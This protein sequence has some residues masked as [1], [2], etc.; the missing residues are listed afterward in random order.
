MNDIK[1]E[2]MVLADMLAPSETMTAEDAEVSLS[3]LVRRLAATKGIGFVKM[4]LI[5]QAL[6][7]HVE[8]S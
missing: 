1:R 7:A 3:V 6:A 4:A 5:A 2:L 8:Q